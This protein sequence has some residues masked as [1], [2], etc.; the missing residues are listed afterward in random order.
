V[1]A[2][3][4]FFRLCSEQRHRW[5][6]WL[7][8]HD[9]SR[10]HCGRHGERGVVLKDTTGN[11][12]DSWNESD[13]LLLRLGRTCVAGRPCLLENLWNYKGLLLH[14]PGEQ[15]AHL[16]LPERNLGLRDERVIS[17]RHQCQRAELDGRQERVFVSGA[18][19]DVSRRRPDP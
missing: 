12:C 19:M 7:R 17:L 6:R 15:R 10:R 16:R 8:R 11:G 3:G 1:K 4:R 13:R 18:V 2:K 9:G 5:K 14:G